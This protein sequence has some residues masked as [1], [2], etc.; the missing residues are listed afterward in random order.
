MVKRARNGATWREAPR[1]L[2]KME[3][4]VRSIVRG[5]GVGC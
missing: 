1:R 2:K 3:I 4:V 5:L